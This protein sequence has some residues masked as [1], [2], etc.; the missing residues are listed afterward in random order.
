MKD[1]YIRYL[2]S[3][4]ELQA[5]RIHQLETFIILE[6]S[7][8]STIFGIRLGKHWLRKHEAEILEELWNS[9]A[10]QYA[11]KELIKS[12]KEETANSYSCF[13]HP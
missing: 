5:Y 3:T 12:F 8:Q 2:E 11:A 7:F 1:E 6:K 10:L 4:I 13:L 9:D